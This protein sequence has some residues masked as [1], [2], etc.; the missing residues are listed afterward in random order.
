LR[1]SFPEG[2]LRDDRI[3]KNMTT[4]LCITNIYEMRDLLRFEQSKRMLLPTDNTDA[5][6]AKIIAKLSEI[7]AEQKITVKIEKSQIAQ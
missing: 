4:Q 5:Y 2:A 7:L 1:T 6:T 3:F